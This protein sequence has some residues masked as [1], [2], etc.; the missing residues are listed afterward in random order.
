[1]TQL[2]PVDETDPQVLGHTDPQRIGGHSVLVKTQSLTP[3]WHR[4]QGLPQPRVGENTMQEQRRPGGGPEKS[5]SSPPPD[6]QPSC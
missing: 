5:L 6:R 1:M 4:A 2:W 3:E